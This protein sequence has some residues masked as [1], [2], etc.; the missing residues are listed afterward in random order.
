[1]CTGIKRFRIGYASGQEYANKPSG[2]IKS[3]VCVEQP[4]AYK[5]MKNNSI[6]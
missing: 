2:L 6:P 1:M 4:K 3:E 5:F